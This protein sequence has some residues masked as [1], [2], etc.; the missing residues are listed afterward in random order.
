MPDSLMEGG[1]SPNKI[2]RRPPKQSKKSFMFAPIDWPMLFVSHQDII[3]A[4]YL[5]VYGLSAKKL[6]VTQP[7]RPTV[8]L[9]RVGS[10]SI[11][12][13][14]IRLSVKNEKNEKVRGGKYK[15]Y[16]DLT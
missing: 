7:I 6:F 3:S 12:R 1:V 11:Y 13:W 10:T 4:G 2:R 14:N 9:A 16:L 15:G 5:G 8:S